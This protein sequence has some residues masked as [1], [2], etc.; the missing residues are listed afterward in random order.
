MIGIHFESNNRIENDELNALKHEVINRN[1][2]TIEQV[3]EI[4]NRVEKLHKTTFSLP[5]NDIVLNSS[6]KK[7]TTIAVN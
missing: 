5:D 3:D 6:T 4:I 7:Q 1:I 2:A